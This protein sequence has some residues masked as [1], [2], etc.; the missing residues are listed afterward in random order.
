M[1]KENKQFWLY[2]LGVV[3]LFFFLFAILRGGFANSSAFLFDTFPF[4]VSAD[5]KPFPESQ[6]KI[7]QAKNYTAVIHTNRGD[8][9]VQLYGQN[10]PNTVSNFIYLANN[11][12]YN[13][14]PFHRYIKGFLIQGGSPNAQTSDPNDDKFGGPGYTIPDEINWDSIGLTQS[15]QKELTAL[16]YT[17]NTSLKS[18]NISKY[19]LVMA[20]NGP[21][22]A[23]S[24]F[25]IILAETNDPRLQD[26]RGKLTVFGRIIGGYVVLEDL[27]KL[28]T[29][30]TPGNDPRPVKF[31]IDSIEIQVQD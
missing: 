20:S 25:A 16:G 12:F 14:L 15:R 8:L 5:I 7:D 29:V 24:Q 3:I 27:S 19:Q 9:T 21:N 30:T 2:Y 10:A 31:E 17:S 26:L 18:I 13:S 11:G 28:E 22:T 6:F 1:F 4:N 23:G